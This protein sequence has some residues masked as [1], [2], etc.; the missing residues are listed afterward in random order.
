[1][2]TRCSIIKRKIS[3]TLAR[4]LPDPQPQRPKPL[5]LFSPLCNCLFSLLT[6]SSFSLALSLYLSPQ[7]PITPFPSP[8]LTCIQTIPSYHNSFLSSDLSSQLI[9]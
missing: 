5:P 8:H 2:L 4:S 7:I 3:H 9:N 6:A 1:M